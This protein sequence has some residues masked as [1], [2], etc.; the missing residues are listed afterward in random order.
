[1]PLQVR[2]KVV[3][4]RQHSKLETVRLRPRRSAAR[5]RHAVKNVGEH[6]RPSRI[7]VVDEV[8]RLDSGA[9]L[10]PRLA[11]RVIHV[12]MRRSGRRLQRLARMRASRLLRI[13]GDTRRQRASGTRRAR[14]DLRARASSMRRADSG[15]RRAQSGRPSTPS[16]ARP[17]RR[18]T[19]RPPKRAPAAPLGVRRRA[20]LA[21]SLASL[22]TRAGCRF[23]RAAAPRRRRSMIGRPRGGRRWWHSKFGSRATNW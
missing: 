17:V 19:P 23:A 8:H 20:G 9:R 14:S 2:A 22:C 18:T 5:V 21:A 10:E 11:P 3:E 15:R 6:R 12:C 13:Y 4:R 1:M 16:R 7:C